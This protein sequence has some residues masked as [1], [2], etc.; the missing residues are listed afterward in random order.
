MN[1]LK[2]SSV[3]VLISSTFLA[4]NSSDT[5]TLE[6][7]IDSKL[8][9]AKVYLRHENENG[10]IVNIDSTEVSNGKFTFE[11]DATA[12]DLYYIAAKG[13]NSGLS[14]ISE[15][16][17]IKA[18]IANSPTELTTIGGTPNNDQLQQ[19]NNS[20]L[21]LEKN[22]FNFQ[23]QNKQKYLTAVEK[24]DTAMVNALMNKAFELNK[25][26]FDFISTF[27]AKNPKSFI[28]LLVL[29][30]RAFSGDTAI[31]AMKKD[32]NGLDANLKVTKIGEVI[33]S[34]IK[35][36]EASKSSN[37]TTSTAEVGKPAPNFSAQDPNGK[38]LQLMEQLGKK[39][40]IIDFW[41]S[42]CNPCRKENPN[43][44]KMYA[45]LHEKGLNIVGVSLD[46]DR[47]AWKKAIEK[48]G[49]TWAQMSNLKGWK[50]PIALQYQ[51][52]EI[53]NTY[54]LDSKGN[55]IAKGLTGERLRQKV[56]EILNK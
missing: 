39:V 37:S 26:K 11:G 40:T 31:Q 34:R 45:E 49:I 29:Q 32:F 12:L 23:S 28:S 18:H 33:Q 9:G 24:K 42:W 46:E 55:I 22:L 10:E 30:Q 41:A 52:N 27:P 8:N 38:S 50:D 13:S 3:F 17:T 56:E 25:K 36:M 2:K 19:F 44:V 4:C 20:Y 43:M 16:G 21:A 14:F 47:N 48:D 35:V 54:L 7:T 15:P 5:F 1:M 53:P 51:I 6:G